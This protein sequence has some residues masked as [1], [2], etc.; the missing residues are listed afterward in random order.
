MNPEENPDN[1]ENPDSE[2][3]NSSE[4]SEAEAVK[5]IAEAIG[6]DAFDISYNGYEITDRYPNEDTEGTFTIS[7]GSDQDSLLV[8][9]F[10]IFNP[11]SETMRCD[12]L[13]LKPS[14][15]F[16]ISGQKHSLLTTLLFNDLVMVDEDIEPGQTYDAVLIAES[17]KAR[18]V[19]LYVYGAYKKFN[20]SSFCNFND[21]K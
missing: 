17:L 19:L 21:V 14:F 12:I 15:R 3:D 11:N 18:L 7:P 1:P 9:H 13:D 8:A 16:T 2:G 5:S 4:G 6:L 10:N 20:Y